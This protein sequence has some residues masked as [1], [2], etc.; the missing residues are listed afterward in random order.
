MDEPPPFIALSD[1][2][3]SAFYN[4]TV[5]NT[6]YAKLSASS[7]FMILRQM[8]LGNFYAKEKPI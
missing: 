3:L 7:F 2:F 6:S 1:L 5:Q 4:N 8:I